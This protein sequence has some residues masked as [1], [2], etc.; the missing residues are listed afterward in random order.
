MEVLLPS[1]QAVKEK[2]DTTLSNTE[3]K[4]NLFIF[5]I[6]GS[7]IYTHLATNIHKSIQLSSLE[8]TF[9]KRR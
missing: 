9:N 6:L 1:L 8:T 7:R 2:I 4:K 5:N 3:Y